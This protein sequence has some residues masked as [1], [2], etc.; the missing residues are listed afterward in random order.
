MPSA[1]VTVTWYGNREA[2]RC[3]NFNESGLHFKIYQVA[4]IWSYD[5]AED[6]IRDM[7]KAHFAS[8]EDLLGENMFI[9]LLSIIIDDSSLATLMH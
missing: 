3:I 2:A 4:I 8:S 6:D 7:T 9:Q 1:W 5:D